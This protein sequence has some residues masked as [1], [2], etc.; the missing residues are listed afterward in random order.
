[1]NSLRSDD[2]EFVGSKY[3]REAT[4]ALK[5]L[6]DDLQTMYGLKRDIV[7]GSQNSYMH[8]KLRIFSL[9]FQ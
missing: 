6:D 3:F 8:P 7:V 5:I 2:N 9:R 4:K 1:M